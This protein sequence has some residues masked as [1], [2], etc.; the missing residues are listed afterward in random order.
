MIQLLL[1]VPG[2]FPD[3][4]TEIVGRGVAPAGIMDFR[5]IAVPGL[6]SKVD[7]RTV[8]RAAGAV[9]LGRKRHLPQPD[10]RLAPSQP[11]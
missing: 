6:I 8:G 1:V 11:P 5:S 10:N 2:P 7:E 9:A 4:H 3:T